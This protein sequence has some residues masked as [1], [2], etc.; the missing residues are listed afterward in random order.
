M[1]NILATLAVSAAMITTA[2]ALS[3]QWSA[4]GIKFGG[5]TLKKSTDVVGYLVYLSSGTVD[6]S[7]NITESTTGTSLA[8]SIGQLVSTSSSATSNGGKLTTDFEFDFGSYNNG[9]VFGALLVY[10]KDGDTFFNLS[11]TTYTLAGISDEGSVLDPAPFTFSYSTAEPSSKVSKGGGWT[12]AAVPEPSTA[13][14]ALG[15]LALLLK[16]RKA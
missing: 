12:A 7:Y 2:S 9:D 1:K 4:S 10:K 6:A 16:R 8:S 3:F 13:V 15:G 14:L 11:S 5:E